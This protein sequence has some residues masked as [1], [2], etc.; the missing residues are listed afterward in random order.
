MKDAS[1]TTYGTT[2]G[3]MEDQF[4]RVKFSGGEP[5]YIATS[6]MMAALALTVLHHRESMKF[7]GGVMLPGAAN[8][9]NV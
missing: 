8:D 5:G 9:E 2:Y 3:L 7:E 4:V 6:A 1:F